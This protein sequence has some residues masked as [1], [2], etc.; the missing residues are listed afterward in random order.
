VTRRLPRL[1]RLSRTVVCV[2][3]LLATS[4]AQDR[5]SLERVASIRSDVRLVLV[6]V[7][8]TDRRGAVLTGLVQEHFKLFEERTPQQ[9]ASF[10]EE[11]V[12]CSVGVVFDVSG[13]M[14]PRLAQAKSALRAFFETANS[15]DEA[16]LM[17]ISSAPGDM[18]GFTTDFGNLL[19]RLQ[20][21]KASGST[22]FIDTVYLAL[23]RMRSAHH[24]RRAL[25]VI[26]DGMDNHSRYSKAELKNMALEA[27]VQIH[28]IALYD[29][30]LNKKPIEL[31]EEKRG[32]LLLDEV[33][34]ET[35]GLHF[36]AANETDV[37]QCITK[38]G[39]ALR[40]EY[41]IGYLPRS[42][43]RSGKW[44]Q[45]QVKTTLRD[46]RVYARSGYYAQ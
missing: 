17:T 28:T 3:A 43:D 11:D 27:D 26:S 9:I 39:K 37:Q 46:V 14:R 15:D 35:G 16:F 41:V 24:A 8:V 12:P 10:K 7:T 36:V 13:S 20:F 19:D 22:A 40:S 18:S 29:P 4:T 23:D 21:R 31:Q 34:R 6:P 5:A 38:I 45:I 1:L 25:L 2:A 42:V 30:P 32:L 44:R 33:S